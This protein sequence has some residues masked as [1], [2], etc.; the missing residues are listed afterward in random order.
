MYLDVVGKFEHFAFFLT[1]LDVITFQRSQMLH[2]SVAD[3]SLRRA[4]ILGRFARKQ[5]GIAENASELLAQ[6]G[7]FVEALLFQPALFA[8]FLTRVPFISG[9]DSDFKTKLVEF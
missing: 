4:R 1:G 8:P 9:F 6:F 2:F 5:T 7:H 3:G